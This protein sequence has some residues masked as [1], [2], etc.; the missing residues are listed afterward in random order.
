MRPSFVDI[1]LDAVA[2]NARTLADL[3]VPAR[4]C[5]VVKADAYGH[6]DV[7]IAET[8][9]ANG[10]TSLAVA[11]VEEGT[12]LRE[13]GISAPIL[14]LS[15]PPPSAIARIVHWDLTPSVYRP[16]FVA[17]LLAVGEGVE[18]G[19]APISVHLKVDTG[20]HRVGA[21]PDTALE[22]AQ[23]IDASPNVVLEGVWTH[24]AV[25]EED[26]DYTRAQI[27]RFREFVARLEEAGISRPLLHA[28]NTA[29]ALLGA[30]AAFD[31]VRVGLGIYGLYPDPGAPAPVELRPAM[32]IVSEVSHVRRYPAGTRPSYGRRRAM[33]HEGNVATVPVGYADG[34]PRRLTLTGGEVLIRGKRFPLAGTVTMDQIVV[35]VGDEPVAVGDEVVLIG[36]QGTETISADDWAAQ[37]GTINYEIVC[38]VG[39]RL[40]R[41]YRP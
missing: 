8:V 19:L 26:L 6:G 14:V 12:R 34:V 3:V 18:G 28:S 7:P 4:L 13:G 5:A 23:A 25:A 29:G 38:Q 40:P 15:E 41:R 21:D 32:R 10:A 24:F 16:E 22:L 30:E 1:D 2:H 11:L 33:P 31:M 39:P 37:L 20:M 36:T 35:D 27:A 17:A 9:L